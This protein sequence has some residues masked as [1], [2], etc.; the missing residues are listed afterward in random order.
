[1]NK[2]IVAY[3]KGF[4]MFCLLN[5]LKQNRIREKLYFFY[6]LKVISRKKKTIITTTKVLS[7]TVT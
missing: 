7:I 5:L 3:L 2:D 4:I 6:Y 1:V